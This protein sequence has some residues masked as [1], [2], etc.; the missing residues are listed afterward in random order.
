MSTKEPSL[1]ITIKSKKEIA[2]DIFLFELGSTD[3]SLLPAY[4][5]GAHI[6]IETPIGA[7]RWYSLCGISEDHSSYFI[8]VKRE[9][10]G[11]GGSISMVDDTEVGTVLK[12][13]EPESEFEFV[14]APAYLLIAGGIGI[15]PIYA[16]WQRLV[17]MEHPDF[18][19]IY[20]TRSP[21]YTPFL[22]ELS[23]GKFA[24]NVEIH[25]SRESG[26]RFDFFDL[27]LTP[28]AQHIYCC[29]PKSLIEE[30][31]DMTGHWQASRL[32]FED[33]KPVEA[34]RKDDKPF[35]VRLAGSD[36]VI[37]VAASETLLDALR[38]HGIKIPSSCESGTCGSCKTAYLEG[39][40]DHRD[41]VLE[42]DEKESFMMPCVSRAEGEEITIDVQN[43][44]T[45][46]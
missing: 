32:H 46:L 25:Y 29:G 6:A 28:T 13:S 45:D 10:D 41:L 15:T 30:V 24:E 35:T 11:R 31:K 27:L 17:E 33:F 5:P 4:E 34:V 7:N 3:G 43:H 38:R 23:Q 36:S 20:L 39:A 21:E 37:E 44:G 16:I 14:E 19:L 40:V 22:E 12:I 2:V 18:K 8:A 26:G 42:D 1:D 9:G